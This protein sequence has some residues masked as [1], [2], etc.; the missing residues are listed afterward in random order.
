[1]SKQLITKKLQ[2]EYI[3]EQY[4]LD[5]KMKFFSQQLKSGLVTK[6]MSP[7]MKGKISRWDF[8][9]SYSNYDH[10]RWGP[11][12]IDQ[13]IDRLGVFTDIDF[14]ND[15]ELARNNSHPTTWLTRTGTKGHEK[16]NS[17]HY[18]EST[19]LEFERNG[20]DAHKHQIF[21]SAPKL[22][23]WCERIRKFIGLDEDS[24]HESALREDGYALVHMQLPLQCVNNHYDTY[25]AIMKADPALQYETYRFRRFAIFLEDWVPGHIWN[26]GNT[27]FT[28]WVKGE[29]ISW[30]WM[31]MPHGT[32]NIC[33][34]PRFSLHLTGYMTDSSYKFYEEG[35]SSTRYNWNK[36]TMTFDKI[37]NQQ[38]II[39]KKIY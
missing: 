8:C 16:P 25:M 19:I 27:S 14:T 4:I 38:Q 17:G 23:E 9:N 28:H 24:A 1:M 18:Q 34:Q 20:L 39:P 35:T 30:D 6:E 15:I 26:F 31:H 37:H 12:N 36:D 10:T 7:R 22:G 11:D 21:N 33:M 5:S 2:S 3:K 13:V 29:V 32:A